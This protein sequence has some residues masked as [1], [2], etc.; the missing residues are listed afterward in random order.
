MPENYDAMDVYM[1]CRNQKIFE[2]KLTESGM[3]YS[4][5]ID[6]SIP[7]VESS[8]R[9]HRVKDREDCLNKVKRCFYHFEGQRGE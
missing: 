1:D 3:P 9:I 4:Q 8:M 5:L 7:A 2:I 6:I